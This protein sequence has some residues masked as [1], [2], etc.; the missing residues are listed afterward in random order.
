MSDH[1]ESLDAAVDHADAVAASREDESFTY[2]EWQDHT[3]D[4]RNQRE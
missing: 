1:V 3:V 2:D 4:P